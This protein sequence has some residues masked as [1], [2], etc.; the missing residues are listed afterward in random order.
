MMR[1]SPSSSEGSKHRG[2][3]HEGITSCVDRN[4]SSERVGGDRLWQPTARHGAD[5][6]GP[7]DG[8]GPGH[9]VASGAEGARSDRGARETGADDYAGA[10]RDIAD[11]VRRAKSRARRD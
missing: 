8:G 7:Y 10:P 6:T 9:D 2:E 4:R 1:R 3:S 11:P 5:G